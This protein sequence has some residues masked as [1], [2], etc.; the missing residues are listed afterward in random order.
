[1]FLT[2]TLPVLTENINSIQQDIAE[3]KALKVDIA[4]IKLLKTDMSEMKASLEFIH[5]SVDALS[6]KI[7]DI[8]REVQELRKTKNYVTTLKKQ[9]EEIL[10]GQRE[11]EQRARLNN[12]EIK[13]VPLSNNENL[14]SLIIKIGEVIKYPITK[15]QINYIARVPIRN[16][17]RNKSIIVSL[18]N[19]YI[20]DDFI[21]AARTRT[22]TPTDLNLRGDNR[23]FINA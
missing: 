20:K 9:F 15:D 6:S 7:T 2:S 5:Q 10:T 22:I 13:G 8:D 12:M 17:K 3:L 4:E 1:M 23:I 19:R 21:A 18:H 16:D 11:H 14:F